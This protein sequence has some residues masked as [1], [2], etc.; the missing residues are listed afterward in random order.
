LTDNKQNYEINM[1]HTPYEVYFTSDD[2]LYNVKSVKRWLKNHNLYNKQLRDLSNVLYSANGVYTNVI[3]YMV[4]LPT[5]DRVVYSSDSKHNNYKSNRKKFTDALETIRD[6]SVIR[7]ILRKLAIDGTAFYYFETKEPPSLP[8]FLD[9]VDVQEITE[10]NA[11]NDSKINCSVLPLP[12][13]YCKM[14][15][16]KNSSPQVA[17]DCSYFD[18]F[19]AKGR[20]KKLL[21]YPPEI[22]K[23]YTAYRKDLNKRWAVLNNEKTLAFKVRAKL[24]DVWGR[25]LGLAAFTD[26]LYEEYFTDSKRNVLDEVNSTIIYQT[27]PEG[28]EKGTSALTQKQQEEQ[29]NNIKRAVFAKG[30]QHGINFFSVAAGTKLDKIKT[31]LDLLTVNAG[32]D[33][34]KSISTSLGFAGSMLNGDGG[35]IGSDKSNVQLL[36]AELFEWLEQVEYEFNKVINAQVIKDK[37]NYIKLSFLPITHANRQETVTHMKELYT[38]AGGSRRAW[39][40]ST[41]MNPDVYLH[42]MDE[43]IEQNFDEKYPPHQTAFTNNG[44][45]T[46]QKP[47]DNNSDNPHTMRN[48]STGANPVD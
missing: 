9:D 46:D 14:I 43:E 19:L 20:S 25:P 37:S 8:K 16:F 15:G 45:L 28:K 13:N 31:N 47:I 27:L 21:R 39:I 10:L 24:D 12:I 35:T 26:M 33:L 42:L 3:D 5:L 18:Q 1:Q 23:A 4:A 41:G 30:L 29:H 36:S 6:K 11:V 7:D 44:E 32:D 17:F 22:R 34:I 40:A 38:H 2:Q 48:K